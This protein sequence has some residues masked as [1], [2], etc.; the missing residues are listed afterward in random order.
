MPRY[1]FHVHNDDITHDQEGKELSDD[2][3]AGSF[4][5]LGARSLAAASVVE[6]HLVLSHFVRVEDADKQHVMTVTFGDA[7]NVRP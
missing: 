6:G 2:L 1:Y 7:V 5:T 4:A 3:A